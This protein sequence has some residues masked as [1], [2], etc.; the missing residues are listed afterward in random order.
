VRR[1]T[2]PADNQ[3]VGHDR[4]P[5]IRV[6]LVRYSTVL[7]PRRINSAHGCLIESARIT[8]LSAIQ[9]LSLSKGRMERARI[10]LLSAE[11]GRGIIQSVTFV[12]TEN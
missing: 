12:L 10:P 6:G 11:C 3:S 4:F 2:C 7:I 9:T 5:M 1:A 8:V